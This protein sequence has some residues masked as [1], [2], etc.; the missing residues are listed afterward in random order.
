MR[1]IETKAKILEILIGAGST[2]KVGSGSPIRPKKIGYGSA[3]QV[4]RCNI[5]RRCRNI[6]LFTVL[7]FLLG[8][9]PEGEAQISH[10][11][12]FLIHSAAPIGT[13]C[14]GHTASQAVL[15][16]QSLFDRLQLRYFYPGA[17]SGSS[18]WLRLRA[19]FFFINFINFAPAPVPGK[20]FF[21]KFH[22]F[23]WRVIFFLFVQVI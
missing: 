4:S 15:W 17:G 16:S 10:A 5:L 2:L 23:C 19:N 22:K 20:I 18:D 21:H 12:P 13:V 14:G 1:Y 7:Y 11:I 3:A 9:R 8:L 6:T